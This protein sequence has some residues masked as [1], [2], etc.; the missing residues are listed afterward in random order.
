MKTKAM[1]GVSG[2]SYA[3]W[4]GNFYP[5]NL[6]SEEFLTYY[7]QRLNSVEINSSFYAPP[8]L[9]MVK[10]WAGKTG[11]NFRFSFKAPR[12]ITHIL[13]LGK[14]SVEATERLGVTLRSLGD[15]N[16]PILFQ[17]PPYS[18]QDLKLLEDFLANTSKIGDR[19]F[20]FRH[21]S[22]LNDLTYA[23]LEKHD[24]D[25]CIAETEDMRPVFK[26]T[27]KT[28]YFRLRRESYDEKMIDD[29]TKRIKETSG[30]SESA[31]VYLRHDETGDNAANA[32]K[33]LES[34]A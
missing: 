24:A 1:V 31:Y 26:V 2:F 18:K 23:T 33:I 20:E 14:G 17:L 4:K 28:P 22:W 34:L 10:S 6:K 9:A 21:E 11:D 8:S 13:K 25:F 32:V 7:S 30:G 27:G 12:Q 19:V 16:G 29:W 15:K 3:G 5:E